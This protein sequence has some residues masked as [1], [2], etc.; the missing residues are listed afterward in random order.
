[1]HFSTQRSTHELIAAQRAHGGRITTPSKP[2]ADAGE[3]FRAS[4]RGAMGA[5]TDIAQAGPRTDRSIPAAFQGSTATEQKL[6]AQAGPA[7]GH[8]AHGIP[9]QPDDDSTTGG[10]TGGPT[11]LPSAGVSL[12]NSPSST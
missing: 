7:K 3:K 11:A 2:A 9:S 1:M 5:H 10:I 12:G 8:R 4:L 6:R